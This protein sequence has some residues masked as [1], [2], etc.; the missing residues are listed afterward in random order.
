MKSLLNLTED[1]SRNNSEAAGS[2]NSKEND[3][4]KNSKTVWPS[5][6][7]RE[8]PFLPEF[9]VQGRI[10]QSNFEV[11]REKVSLVIFIFIMITFYL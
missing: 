5:L 10:F 4:Y 9:Q 11:S 2:H 7:F 3:P 6:T 8:I 1:G